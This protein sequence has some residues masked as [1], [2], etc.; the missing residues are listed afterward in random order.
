[1]TVAVTLDVLRKCA[2]QS[3]LHCAQSIEG[4][5]LVLHVEGLSRPQP[6]TIALV[7]N[8]RIV[9]FQT[10]GY[11]S[12]RAG[13][14]H[15]R[16]VVTLLRGLSGQSRLVRYTW[17]PDKSEIVISAEISVGDGEFTDEQFRKALRP[18]LQAIDQPTYDRIKQTIDTGVDPGAHRQEVSLWL[19]ALAKARGLTKKFLAT[20]YTP[21]AVDCTVFSQRVV[22]P[23]D[24]ILI[25]VFAYIPSYLDEARDLAQEYDEE[26]KRLGS[27]SLA[28]EIMR[29]STLT[30]E[31]VFRDL[32]IQDSVQNLHWQGKT[33]SVQFEVPILSDYSSK[34]VIGKVLISQ[35]TVPIGQI[36]F[37]IRV[38]AD[39][40]EADTKYAPTGDARRY[41]L[42]FISYASKD[43]LEVLRRVQMLTAVGIRYF[44]DLLSLDSGDRWAEKI[45]EYID[46]SDVLFLFW[47][48][49]ARESEW[50]KREWQYGLKKNGDDFIHPVIIEGPPPP[51]PPPE[52]AHLHFADK[53]LYFI[54]PR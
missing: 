23:G 30:F 22:Q 37:K 29:G 53:L 21:D 50:V 20:P 12:C 36:L 7:E 54:N 45:Y 3:G 49:A 52:L 43:R 39:E 31:L 51:A 9:Q 18:F 1:M 8:G 47:S 27:V 42:A 19:T 13:D 25:Q 17:D 46:Q 40:R 14:R 16:E 32:A 48:T 41:R 38:A 26:A 5:W 33:Q 15:L 35:N 10:V 6:F 44:Q 28:T 4:N 2:D 34:N 24:C 11:L